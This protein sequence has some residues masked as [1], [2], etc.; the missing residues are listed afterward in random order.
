MNRHTRFDLGRF[1][2]VAFLFFPG[3]AVFCVSPYLPLAGFVMEALLFV[4]ISFVMTFVVHANEAGRPNFIIMFAD[5]LGYGTL[6]QTPEEGYP[7][8]EISA[9]HTALTQLDQL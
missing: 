7:Q 4:A 2:F 1:F 9:I 8:S 5:D 3:F 6:L